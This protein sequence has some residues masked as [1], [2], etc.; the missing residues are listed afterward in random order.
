MRHGPESTG[1]EPGPA[2]T[3]EASFAIA[4]SIPGWLTRDQA[5]VLDEAART[6]PPAGTIVEIG[7]HRGRSAVVLARA[8][9]DDGR[10]VAVDPFP[11][12]WRYG[13]DGTEAAFRANVDA[14]GAAE[15]VDLRVA[16]SREV[17][18]SW[19]G[20]VEGVYVDGKHDVWSLRDDLRWAAHVRPGGW[21]LVHD[22]F[23]SL[24]VT[25]GLLSVLPLSRHLRY[26]ERTGSLARLEVARPTLRDRVRPARELPWF[27]RNL[28]VK[29]LLRLHLTRIAGW[30]GHHDAADPY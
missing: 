5:R 22:A 2:G 10:L 16:T 18:T 30:L 29:V 1:P 27:V 17:R 15:R 11:V 4:D 23:S 8:L 6:V 13:D 12:D 21:V 25:L 7:S 14:A 9:G 19:E 26:V 24:G 28:V 20:P 3:F